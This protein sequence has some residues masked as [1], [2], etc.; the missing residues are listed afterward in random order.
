MTSRSTSSHRSAGRLACVAGALVAVCSAA[1]A[2][3]S[4][5]GYSLLPYTERGYVG[6]NVGRPK[7]QASCGLGGF[8]CDDP[9]ASVHAYTGGLFNPFLGAEIGYLNFGEGD[10]GGGNTRAQGVNLSLTAQVP[11]SFVRIF[12]KVGG[13]YS[14]TRVTASFASGLPTGKE[15]GWGASYGAGVALDF[16]TSSAIV[17]GWDRHDLRYPGGGRDAVHITSLGYQYRF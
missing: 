11:I 10:R 4:G 8:G 9:S 17:L 15:R 5:S 12:G 2:Q 3:S 13:T 6:I 16:G 7:Y 1:P 14:Q